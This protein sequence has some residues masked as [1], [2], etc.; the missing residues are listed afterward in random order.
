MISKAVVAAGVALSLCAA[1]VASTEPAAAQFRHGG[2]GGGFHGGMG[3]FGGGWHGGMGGFGGGWHGGG[4]GGWHGGMGGWHGGV[5]GWHGGVGGWRTA[6]WG[7]GWHGVGGWR[8]AG[9]GGWRGHGWRGGWNGCRWG[10]CGWGSGWWWPF[11]AGTGV[12]LAASYPYYGDYGY[13]Y[14]DAYDN[15]CYQLQPIYSRHGLYLGRRWV[16][17]CY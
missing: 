11:A 10:G 17:V 7:G 15:G 13:G 12:A 9:W 1:L 5:G 14:D 2:F 8:T 6:G 16:N 3:G 4:M